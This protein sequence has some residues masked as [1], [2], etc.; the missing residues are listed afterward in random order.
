[1]SAMEQPGRSPYGPAA[2]PPRAPVPA[3]PDDRPVG[4]RSVPVPVPQQQP[5]PVQTPVA[6]PVMPH[7]TGPP[8]APLTQLGYWGDIEQ[9]N[10]AV[11]TQHQNY[12]ALNGVPPDPK[13]MLKLVTAPAAAPTQPQPGDL[14]ARP[15]GVRQPYTPLYEAPARQPQDAALPALGSL[16][17]GRDEFLK[18]Y[19]MTPMGMLPIPSFESLVR[20]VSGASARQ[21]P[22]AVMLGGMPRTQAEVESM[23]AEQEQKRAAYRVTTIRQAQEE[24]NKVMGTSLP[25]TGVW[26]QTWATTTMNWSRTLD[27]DKANLAFAAKQHGLSVAQYVKSWENQRKHIEQGG[28]LGIF[29]H[30]FEAMPVQLF[31]HG[32]VWGDLASIPVYLKGSSN[33]PLNMGLHGLT[34]TAGMTLDVIGGTVA[35]SKADLAFGTTLTVGLIEKGQG[36]PKT[37]EQIGHEARQQLDAHPS[38]LR[39][40]AGGN[41]PVDEPTWLRHLDQATNIVLDL[42]ALRKPGLTGE[43]VARGDIGLAANSTYLGAASKW[44]FRDMAAYGKDGI[45]RASSRLESGVGARELVARSAPLVKNG[46]MTEEQFQ[47]HVAELYAHGWT[48]ITYPAKEGAKA[49]SVI[50]RGP[51]LETLASKNLPSPGVPGRA[52]IQTKTAIRNFAD[53][54]ATSFKGSSSAVD[55]ATTLRS[56]VSHYVNPTLGYFD[57]ILPENVF[58]FVI[59][60]K[61][62]DD[63]AQLANQIESQL[64]RFQGTNNVRGIQSVQRKLQQ[65]YYEK[66]PVGKG[67][68]HEEDPFNAILSTEAPSV[69]RFPVKAEPEVD[70]ALQGI[71]LV[72]RRTNN[73]LTRLAKIHGRI[74]LSGVN[75]IGVI[76]AGAGFAAGGPVGALA[77][78]GVFGPGMSLFWKHAIGDTLRAELGGGGILTSSDPAILKA[79]REIQQLRVSDPEISRRLGVFDEKARNNEASWALGHGG[80]TFTK[81]FDTGEKFGKSNYMTAA[82]AYLRRHLDDP[83]LNAYQ[84]GDPQALTQLVLHDP[85]Y[86]GMWKSARAEVR[87]QGGQMPDLTS[88][89]LSG[90]TVPSMTAE[91]YAALLNARFKSLSDAFAAKGKTLDDAKAFYNTAGGKT[92]KE[93]GAWIKAN[94]LDFPVLSGQVGVGGLD[95]LS[96]RWVGEVV[97]RPNKWNRGRFAQNQLAKTYSQ[98]RAAGFDQRDALDSATSVASALTKYHMLDFANRLQVEQDLRWISYFATKHRLYY[99]WVLGTLV[100]HPGYAA[101]VNDFKD[102][103]NQQGGWALPFEFAGTKWQ[104]PLERLVWVPGREYDETSPLANV[105]FGT[106]ASGGGLDQVFHNVALAGGGNVITRSDVAT[107]LGT[108]LL[109]TEIGLHGA[110]YAYATSGL[111]KTMTSRINTWINEYQLAYQHEHGTLAP[112]S[113]AVKLAL[114]HATGEEYWRANMPFPVIP[115]HDRTAEQALQAEFMSN[116]DPAARAKFLRDHPGFSDHFGIYQDP[117]VFTHN[118]PLFRRWTLGID[119]YRAG[120][121]DITAEYTKTGVYTTEME[122]K[123][124]ALSAGLNKLHDQLLIDDAKG[125]GINTNGLV[126]DGSTVEFGPWGKVVNK[127]PFFDPSHQLSLLFPKLAPG[128]QALGP[129][130]KQMQQELNK[131]SGSYPKDT[132]M[133]AAQVTARRVELLQKLAVFKAYPTDALGELHNAY[134]KQVDAYWK[135]YDTHYAAAQKAPSSERGTLDAAFRAW[136]DAQDHPVKVMASGEPTYVVGKPAGLLTRGTIDIANRPIVQNADGTVSTVRSI[137][138][139][140]GAKYVLLPTVV[141]DAVVSNKAAIAHYRKTGEHLGIFTSETA[142]DHYAVALHKEQAGLKSVEFPSPVRMYWATMNP[143]TRHERLSYLSSKPLVDLAGYELDLLGVKHPQWASAAIAATAAAVRDA[144][145]KGITVTKDVRLS[146]A[147]QIDKTPGYHGYLNFYVKSLTQP[148]VVQFEQTSVYKTMNTDMRKRFDE[149]AAAAVKLTGMVAAESIGSQDASRG[150]R[151]AVREQITPWLNDPH[152]ADLKKYLA[153]MGPNF[154]YTLV[155]GASAGMAVPKAGSP[156]G[157]YVHPIGYGATLGR[158]DQGVDFMTSAPVKALGSGVII[159]VGGGMAGGTGTIIKQALDQPVTVNGRTYSAV[160]YSEQKPLVTQGQQ[161]AAG[162]QVMGAGGNELGFLDAN[163]NMA[164]LVGGV[165]AGSQPTQMGR[166]FADFVRSLKGRR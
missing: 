125:W 87:K 54:H 113:Q 160:Y 21:Q 19:P 20:V 85:V 34:R 122:K 17:V 129:L 112:E 50:V 111:T 144:Q 165:G 149:I 71:E 4:P 146:I 124:R 157:G 59:K 98:L 94:E 95:G 23:R 32:G 70:T 114:L 132:G 128:G 91:D 108:K 101:A 88:G 92:D 11:Q 41:L 27:A 84:S 93:L 137:T 30:F 47:A 6:R 37:L 79:K 65:L 100:R 33:N 83:A 48:R 117:K 13:T 72:A 109:A 116:P 138:I 155:S 1:M 67:V 18:R 77:G 104:I 161:V 35:Q 5:R 31:G 16:P 61:L 102:T 89:R 159:S 152:N 131:L 141:G 147:Q 25:V 52:L 10:Q 8:L 73:A 75:P 22:G 81:P 66:N 29:G 130:Q 46:T 96:S 86:Q 39:M 14:I 99:K 55:F 107:V 7:P 45:G 82:G 105:V 103:L 38:W 56:A 120:R 76:G 78:F 57:K 42:V 143:V 126:P 164:P 156:T 163:G 26:N 153:P 3:R 58:N 140:E 36:S 28:P 115:S 158:I 24:L 15:D 9:F 60:N 134:Q 53:E 44:A 162:D 40:V 12:V 51:V 74:I 63:T 68:I 166:D 119:A 127:D 139:Q 80:N 154:L 145:N 69:F 64:V 136:R 150:W 135:G 121:A 2:P 133:T 62:G 142:A 90:S 151:T 106:L 148:R 118:Q 110:T 97:M 49:R 43:V 123:R